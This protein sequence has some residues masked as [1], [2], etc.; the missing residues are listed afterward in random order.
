MGC[1]EDSDYHQVVGDGTSDQGCG[2]VCQIRVVE[3]QVQVIERA[4]K[5]STPHG[6]PIL[7]IPQ[8]VCTSACKARGFW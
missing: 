8:R 2:P 5:R 7:R 6:K 4:E 1:E 3:S